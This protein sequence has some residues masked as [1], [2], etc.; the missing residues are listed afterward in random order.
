MQDTTEIALYAG[1][2]AE[3]AKDVEMILR[4]TISYKIIKAHE[5]IEGMLENFSLL[6]MPGGYTAN[7]IPNLK[8]KG[9]AA[10]KKFLNKIGG[11]YIGICAG[12]YITSDLGI[13]QSEMIR[14][15]GIFN[16]YIE[17]CD[18]SHPIFEG[19]KTTKILVYYQNGPHI[20]PHPNEKSL[21]LYNDG[22]S[23]IIET[24]NA[25]IFSWH[26]EKMPSTAPILLK[27]IQYL[28]NPK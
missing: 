1:P 25:L 17:L 6:I 14:E 10:I 8:Q 3:L 28:V 23:S 4:N 11:S 26:P 24:K 18:L 21:A 19:Q 2:G 7:Y 12:A 16:C 20:V 13:S 5:I 22:S 15:S 9:C 27:S